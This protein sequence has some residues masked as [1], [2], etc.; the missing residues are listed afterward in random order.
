MSCF[1]IDKVN[2]LIDLHNHLEGALSEKT[3][4][5]LGALCGKPV[6]EDPEVLNDLIRAPEDCRD[7]NQFL[8]KFDLA[9]EMLQTRAC[10]TRAVKNTVQELADMG[11]V[12]AEL[13]YGPM[14]NTQEGLTQEEALQA[15]IEGLKDA[16]IPAGLIICAMR[17]PDIHE[18]NM[19]SIRLA[20]KY[21]GKGVVA[22]DLAGAEAVFPTA[23]FEEEFKLAK[24]LGIPYTIHAGKAAG[25]ESVRD[26]LRF[27]AQRLGHGVRS[28][29]D[30]ELVKELAE[31]KIPLELCV[32]SNIITSIYDDISEYPFR[33]LMEAGVVL[34]I[35]SDDPTVCNTDIRR[36]WQ[37][38]VRAFDLNKEECRQLLLNAANAAFCDEETR[39]TLIAK[40][41]EEFEKAGDCEGKENGGRT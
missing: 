25:P 21:L 38:N 41:E 39:K 34:T 14:Y 13:R 32:K 30:P 35:N 11:A 29:E 1:D 22:I 7:L 2:C 37:Q 18:T 24:E 9:T 20:K 15:A 26:A 17:L 36:E 6:P 19:E 28:V 23:D 3:F 16:P 12:Y 4:R 31:R 8:T 33:Q 27:G 40:I 5:E 10:L